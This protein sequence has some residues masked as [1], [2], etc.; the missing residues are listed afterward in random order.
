ME[1]VN[2]HSTEAWL[3]TGQDSAVH[4]HLEDKGHSFE[5][6][7]VLIFIFIVLILDREERWFERGSKKSF[8]SKL[9]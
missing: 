9:T 3:N 4:P 8:T 1:E 5:D 7:N 6:Q 2:N